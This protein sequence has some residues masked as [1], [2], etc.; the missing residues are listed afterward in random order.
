MARFNQFGGSAVGRHQRRRVGE[1]TFRTE[2]EARAY[3][4]S[5][6]WYCNTGS[7][8]PPQWKIDSARVFLRTS[9]PRGPVWVLRWDRENCG[10]RPLDK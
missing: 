1:L 3:L 9:N 5:K 10:E 8:F 2:T 6:R 4:A 7:Y